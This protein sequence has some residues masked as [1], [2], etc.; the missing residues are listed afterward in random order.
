MLGLFN[1]FGR[2]EGLKAI[3][4]ALREFDIHPRVVPEAVKLATIRLMQ[5]ASNPEY[6]L[7]DAD[8]K[9]ASEL[10][11]Y[12]ILGPDQFVASNTL[13]AAKRA[14]QRLEE[15]ISAGDSLDAELILLAVHSGVIHSTIAEQFDIEG[16]E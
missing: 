2:S 12:S 14:E 8:Y 1:I 16:N 7:C 6:V 15:A 3:D 13:A 4:Q 11:S 10:L 5:K 9:R